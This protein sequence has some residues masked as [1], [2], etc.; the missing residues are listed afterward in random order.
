VGGGGKALELL[1]RA[2]R[3]DLEAAARTEAL[4]ATGAELG[5]ATERLVATTRRL[6]EAMM[7]DV[8]R[9]LANASVY[10]DVFGHVVVAWMWLRQ[11]LAATRA[12]EGKG[13]A[14]ADFYRGKL[15]A[16]RYFFRWEL[17]RI[18]PQLA[19]LDSLD[20]TCL[21]AQPAWL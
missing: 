14:D 3:P 9:G 21:E 8:E 10:L 13:A 18:G 16:C 17:P 1:V 4:R 12:L 19:L 11:A 6:A 5:Q 2:M 7:S 15:A 20:T